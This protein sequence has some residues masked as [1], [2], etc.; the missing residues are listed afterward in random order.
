MNPLDLTET[1][2]MCTYAQ[3]YI[4]TIQLLMDDVI[5][6]SSDDIGALERVHALLY[7]A[8]T[9]LDKAQD[10]LEIFMDSA[11]QERRAAQRGKMD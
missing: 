4:Q 6:S 8:D 2:V 1:A 7:A 3:H 9:V 11:A 5:V 10:Q